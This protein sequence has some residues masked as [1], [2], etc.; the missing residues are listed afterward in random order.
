MIF[1]PPMIFVN[2]FLLYGFKLLYG[3]YGAVTLE[4]QRLL[5]IAISPLVASYASLLIGLES[6]RAFDRVKVW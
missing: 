2:I 4:L 1:A 3:Y 6:I 5:M